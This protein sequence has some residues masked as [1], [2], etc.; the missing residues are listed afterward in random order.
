MT[1]MNA[2]LAAGSAPSSLDPELEGRL[3][4][5]SQNLDAPTLRYMA[6]FLAGVAAERA[7]AA[8]GNVSIK[9]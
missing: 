8:D 3:L 5:L 7:R 9:R 2:S 6:G 1:Y 4:S